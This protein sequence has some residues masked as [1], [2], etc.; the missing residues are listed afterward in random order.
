MASMRGGFLRD[1][2][3]GAVVVSGGTGGSTTLAPGTVVTYTGAAAQRV[4]SLEATDPT[5][6]TQVLQVKN[7]GQS[8]SLS[9]VHNA[10]SANANAVVMTSTNELDTTLG[11]RGVEAGRGTIKATHDKPPSGADD[12][13]ASVLSIRANG[14][15]TKAQGLFFD[16]EDVGGTS[17]HLQQWRQ[18]GRQRYVVNADGDVI[19]GGDVMNEYFMLR[20]GS[21][22]ATMPDIL[23]TG[24]ATI[25][26][27]TAVGAAA[28]VRKAPAAGAPFGTIRFF[29][30]STAPSALTDVRGC[31]WSDTGV[32]LAQTANIAA[33]I[34]A[35]NLLV[36]QPLAAPVTLTEG[37]RVYLGVAS[38]GTTLGLAAIGGLAASRT[39]ARS[40]RAFV[41][42]RSGS[43]FVS[44]GT[45]PSLGAT[46][47]GLFPFVELDT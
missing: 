20:R 28:F 42:S 3:T 37:Q 7:A 1:D 26:T 10:A 6:P 23:A 18:V 14:V 11:I 4:L 16:A 2:A 27:G 24:N 22:C 35:A 5:F 12:A 47:S 44:A 46:S 15:G 36:E 34:T 29:T 32:L 25:G 21:D 17:G 13:N 30:S 8:H 31:V 9:V 45:P 38:V 19:V 39:A 41:L 43:G 33:A 40:K